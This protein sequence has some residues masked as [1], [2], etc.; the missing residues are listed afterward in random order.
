MHLQ[1]EFTN[2]EDRPAEVQGLW[3]GRG[4]GA[5][6][7]GSRRPRIRAVSYSWAFMGIL[8][9]DLLPF[10]S[11]NL[12]F[13]KIFKK[14]LFSF[15]RERERETE[16]EQGRGRERGRQRIP[17]RFHTISTELD[18]GLEHTNCELMT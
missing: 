7:S 3:W 5:L 11:I 4:P 2:G 14:C 6:S 13:K 15:E 1:V 12:L 17:S 9:I 16:S 18:M 10:L 8:H